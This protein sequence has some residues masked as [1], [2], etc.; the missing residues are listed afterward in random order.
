MLSA[1]TQEP[2]QISFVILGVPIK[3]PEM[4]IEQVPCKLQ[5]ANIQ[6]S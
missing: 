2:L 4:F 3:K 6:F 1:H 5:E